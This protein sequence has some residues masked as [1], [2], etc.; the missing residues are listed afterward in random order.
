MVKTKLNSFGGWTNW[1]ISTG[2]TYLTED[3]SEKPNAVTDRNVAACKLCNFAGQHTDMID[4]AFSSPF[5][6]N[7]PLKPIS[8]RISSPTNP[9]E[10]TLSCREAIEFSSIY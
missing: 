4:F 5:M 9:G 6:T 1:L 2:S 3:S 8:C 7:W 10:F